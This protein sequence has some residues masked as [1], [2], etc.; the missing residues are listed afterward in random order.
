MAKRKVI[1]AIKF[2]ESSLIDSGLNVS[3]IILFGSQAKGSQTKES[4]V[5]LIIISD[6]F[7]GC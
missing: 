4:D 5:D 2:L 7:K 6:D 3:K 1:E